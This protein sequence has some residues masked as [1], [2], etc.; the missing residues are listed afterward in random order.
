MLHDKIKND[1]KEA[2][3]ARDEVRLRSARNVLATLTNELVAKGKTPQGALSDEEVT[4]VIKRIAKQH[5][6]SIEQF[7]QGERD[8][9]V[10]KEEAEFAYLEQYLPQMMSKDE[11]RKIAE[12]K[13]AELG[14]TDK[15]GMGQFIGALMKELKGKAD[16][17][18]VKDVVEE[19]LTNK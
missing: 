4:T 7:R 19:L 15:S 6:D 2:L 13:K 8:D 12:A 11:I 17:K 18:D 1:I 10:K 14:I 3:K 5:K 9:L 16:G